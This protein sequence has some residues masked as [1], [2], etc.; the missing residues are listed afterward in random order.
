MNFYSGYIEIVGLMLA[1]VGFAGWLQY[2]QNRNEKLLLQE[3]IRTFADVIE[4]IDDRA[5]MQTIV[6]YKF[7]DINSGEI[8]IRSGVLDRKLPIPESG[9]KIEIVFL[10]KNPKISRLRFEESFNQ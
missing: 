4:S 1:I 7:V 8:F 5:D 9:D 2:S 10:S 3:G 6:K